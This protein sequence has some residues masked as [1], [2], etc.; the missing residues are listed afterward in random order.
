MGGDQRQQRPQSAGRDQEQGH[1]QQ[2][3][4]H[5]RCA[6]RVPAAGPQPGEEP[7][8][9]LRGPAQPGMAGEH[10]RVEHERRRV[11]AEHG[12][13]PDPGDQQPADRR[14]DDPGEVD[15]DRAEGR[16]GRYLRAGNHVGHQRLVGGF[17]QDP[18]GAEHEGEHEQQR[19]RHQVRGRQRGQ[20]PARRGQAGQ[21]GEQQP[22]PVEDVRQHAADHREQDGGE[23]VGRLHEG[24]QDGRV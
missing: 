9:R 20:R 10:D 2:D 17:G 18:A 3:A 15:G 19:G 11:Q 7:L 13:H 12:G 14:A 21:H 16:G 24:N 22:D 4:L 8:G 1:P 6:A 5:D 23:G